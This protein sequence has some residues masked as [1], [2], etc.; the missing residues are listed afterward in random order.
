MT[1]YKINR[2]EMRI[3]LVLKIVVLKGF[4]F[5]LIYFLLFLVQAGEGILVKNKD[6]QEYTHTKLCVS[7]AEMLVK[8]FCYCS[9]MVT[10]WTL[11]LVQ[12]L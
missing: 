1:F 10:A 9:L 5:F 11:W 2:K 8:I 12:V 7:K 6:F 4:F 3:G